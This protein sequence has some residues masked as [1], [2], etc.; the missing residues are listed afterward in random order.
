MSARE[1]EQD[2]AEMYSKLLQEIDENVYLTRELCSV[3][4][5]I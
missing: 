2:Y 4:L 3:D 5:D 1:N